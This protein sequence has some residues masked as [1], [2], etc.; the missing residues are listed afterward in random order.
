[1]SDNKPAGQFPFPGAAIILLALGVFIFNDTPFQPSRPDAPT[2]QT[3]KTRDVLA[4]L[5]QDPFE[6]VELHQINKHT[7]SEN[8]NNHSIKDLR[9]TINNKIQFDETKNIDL[10][11]LAIMVS[12]G[13]YAEN[14]ENRIRSRYAVTTGL[15]SIGY[16]PEDSEHIKYLSFSDT[17]KTPAHTK[18]S[19]WPSVIPFEWY[20][21]EVFSEKW[22]NYGFSKNIL[23]LWIDEDNIP[24]TKPLNMLADLKTDISSITTVDNNQKLRIKFDVIG[25]S[26]S[27]TLVKMYANVAAP[28]CNESSDTCHN[29]KDIYGDEI[30]KIRV[31]SPRA[32]LDDDAISNILTNK[33]I[34]DIKPFP[35]LHRTIAT[36]S[37]LVD[38]LLCEMLR[39]EKQTAPITHWTA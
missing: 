11:I 26:S 32:T 39:R 38:N 22:H 14:R 35:G 18:Y 34:G 28:E 21:P 25:P 15:L 7:K 8:A 13:P 2:S 24:D 10:H 27:T 36:D 16:A 1:M 4:R 3:V 19:K 6:A 30:D 20:T 31:F 33:N 12:G 9:N 23:V 37:M 5:W 29:I 17:D